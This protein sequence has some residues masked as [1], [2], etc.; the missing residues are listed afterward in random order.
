[1]MEMPW[2]NQ[3]WNWNYSCKGKCALKAGFHNCMSQKLQALVEVKGICR[4]S[5]APNVKMQE[6]AEM[7]G[8]IMDG[9]SCCRSIPEVSEVLRLL[10]TSW[11]LPMSPDPSFCSRTWRRYSYRSPHMA[12]LTFATYEIEMVN[13]KVRP[14]K[15]FYI[16]L[17]TTGK[18]GGRCWYLL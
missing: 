12:L 14:Q 17:R 6:A 3:S 9:G 4:D 8:W 16:R 18:G 10:Y 5:N 2:F 15:K 1:M 13:I 7:V 11:Q